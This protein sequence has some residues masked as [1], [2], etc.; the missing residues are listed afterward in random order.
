LFFQYNP[1]GP[2][3]GTIHWGHAASSDRN[4][5]CFRVFLDRSVLELFFGNAPCITQRLYPKREDSVGLSFEVTT[6]SAIVHRLSVWRLAPIWP[7]RTNQDR[8]T[9]SEL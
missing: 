1:H 3:W 4:R 7:D 5:V 6:G 9:A 8:M 2:F